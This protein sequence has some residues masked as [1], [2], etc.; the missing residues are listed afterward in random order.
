[1]VGHP[2]M[3]KK[4]LTVFDLWLISSKLLHDCV[5]QYDEY[6]K[7]IFNGV[8]TFHISE[9]SRIITEKKFICDK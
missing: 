9:L 1:M 6:F 5:E 7:Q 8:R 2:R 4:I 3:Y